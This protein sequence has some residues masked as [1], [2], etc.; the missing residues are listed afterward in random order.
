M[1]YH[2]KKIEEVAAHITLPPVPNRQP[3]V[4]TVAQKNY[5]ASFAKMMESF[6]KLNTRITEINNGL[7][8][9]KAVL[10]K[11]VVT[12]AEVHEKPEPEPKPEPPTQ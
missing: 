4:K 9:Q 10:E 2:R 1:L 11:L 3:A 7:A 12:D 6:E 8:E 5:D